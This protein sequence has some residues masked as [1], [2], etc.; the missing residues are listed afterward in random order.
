V[1][2]AEFGFA[3][4]EELRE[5]AVDVAEAE[6]AEV[7][8]VNASSSGAN[9]RLILLRQTRRGSAAL[10]P[11]RLKPAIERGQLWQRWKRCATQNQEA[12]SIFAIRKKSSGLRRHCCGAKALLFR[13]AYLASRL[14]PRPFKASTDYAL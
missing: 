5:G 13:W 2:V 10:A 14:K 7:V 6:E 9:A 3:V 1:A 4:E 8:G 11:Q 12:E